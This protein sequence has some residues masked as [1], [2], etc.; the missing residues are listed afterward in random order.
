M[1]KYVFKQSREEYWIVVGRTRDYMVIPGKYCTCD[2]FFI[3]VVTGTRAKSCYHLLAQKIAEDG[4]SFETYEVD[5][6][7]GER[8]LDE[9]LEP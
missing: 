4:G 7:E 5:D 8:L 3:N 6:D 1:K 9:W 2:D